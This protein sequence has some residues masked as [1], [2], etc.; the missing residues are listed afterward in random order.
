VVSET[1]RRSASRGQEEKRL[2][3]S[4]LKVESQKLEKDKDN[5]EAQR[6][7]RFAEHEKRRK[8]GR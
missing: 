4:K 7:R 5:A 8:E 1:G 3:S 2:K 6:T